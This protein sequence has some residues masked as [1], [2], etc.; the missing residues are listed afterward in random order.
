MIPE[1]FQIVEDDF[2]G[3]FNPIDLEGFDI[4]MPSSNGGDQMSRNNHRV[5]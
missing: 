1:S 5:S 4:D 3:M 2:C